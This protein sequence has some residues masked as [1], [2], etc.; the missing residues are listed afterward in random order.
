MSI[1]VCGLYFKDAITELKHGNIKCTTTK[2][3]DNNLLIFVLFES[4]SHSGSGWFIHDTLYFK[5]GNFTSILGCLALRIVEISWD[6]NDGLSDFFAQ[7]GLGIGFNLAKNH[8]GNAFWSVFFAVEFNRDVAIFIDNLVGG[9]FLIGLNLFVV[10]FAPHQTLDA[11]NRVFWIC[12]ALTLSNLT[13][14]AVALLCNSN[15]G[16][17]RT[18]T[19]AVRNNLWFTS[20]HIRKGAVSS[21]K[22]NTNDFT[23][24]FFLLLENA[25]V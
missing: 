21:T 23:H 4:I 25:F 22:V 2:V 15:N 7:E 6:R 20:N 13:N 5:T 24:L 3:E 11:I 16:R 8:S 9:I 1:T 12:D 18:I 17:G 19:F 14:E 10:I